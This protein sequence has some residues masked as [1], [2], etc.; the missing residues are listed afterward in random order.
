MIQKKLYIRV[1][2]DRLVNYFPS[3]VVDLSSHLVV[4]IYDPK[5]ARSL[6]LHG[7]VFVDENALSNAPYRFSR[8]CRIGFLQESPIRELSKHASKLASRFDLV[9]THDQSLI[10]LGG[11]F[12]SFFYG[13][14]WINFGRPLREETIKKSKLCSFVGSIAHED[15]YGYQIRKEVVDW[16]KGKPEIDLWG[17]GI[18]PFETKDEVMLPYQFSIAMENIQS[19]FYFTEKLIDCFVTNTVPIYWGGS[20]ISEIFDKRG[21]LLFN[22]IDELEL[23]L[24]KLS[25]AL[26]QEMLPYVQKNRKIAFDQLLTGHQTLCRRLAMEAVFSFGENPSMSTP[27][28]RS[29]PFALFRKLLQA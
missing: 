4:L 2:D 24:S 19:D 27:W 11:P 3:I 23:L 7:C 26:Y 21:M 5:L 16:A 22:S 9:L 15:T 10:D 1:Y 12:K 17:K 20:R 25:P 13:T 8:A 14:S 29:K 18:A 6:E 28:S